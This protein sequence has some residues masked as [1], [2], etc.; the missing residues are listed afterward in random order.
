MKKITIDKIAS[1]T[2]N[3]P[4]NREMEISEQIS[5]EGGAIV[6]GEVLD[7]SKTY[8]QLELVSGRLSTLKSGDVVALALGKRRALKGF[9]GD[10]PSELKVGD[11]IHVLN[12]GGVAGICTSENMESVGKAIRVKVLGAPVKNGENL[13]ISQEKLFDLSDN[14]NS[15][16]PLIVVSGTCMNVGKTSVA[17]EIISHANKNGFRIAGTKLAGVACLRD[18]E[19]MKDYG[20]FDAVSF[21]DAGMTSTIGQNDRSLKVTKGALNFLAEKNPDFI[22]IEFGDGIFGE[23]GVRSILE[24][25]EIQENIVAH[26]G[27]AHDPMGAS[28][29]AETCEE[30]GV[31]LSIISGPVTDNSVGQD[32]IEKE[33]KIKSFNSMY[34]NEKMFQYL[35]ENY[36]RKK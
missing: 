3:I 33:L 23:Y 6:V 16:V 31:P 29:L 11:I 20:A 34:Y 28:K 21:L 36:L 12:I 13:N 7:N 14:L 30:I 26:V 27:C 32:F 8:N 35:L 19:K 10:L 24:D 2:K 18:A 1:A 4:L 25:K 22:I 5:S 17:C 15:K 9:V